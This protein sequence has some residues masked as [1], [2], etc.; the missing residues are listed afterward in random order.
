VQSLPNRRREP[1][2][3][4]PR[5]AVGF[6][7]FELTKKVPVT[8]DK[9]SD[10]D[11]MENAT[12]VKLETVEDIREAFGVLAAELLSLR[13]MEV[14]TARLAQGMDARI[15]LLTA[16]VDHLHGVLGKHGMVPPRP[17]GGSLAN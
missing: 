9:R 1:S 14:A 3:P 5:K 6:G 16:L 7:N 13:E 10:G 11:S 2:R 17:K 12:A 15:K 8:D 4:R